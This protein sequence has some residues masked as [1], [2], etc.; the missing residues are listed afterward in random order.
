MIIFRLWSSRGIVKAL[1]CLAVVLTASLGTAVALAQETPPAPAKSD[2]GATAT[3]EGTLPPEAP[4]PAS[5]RVPAINPDEIVK[6]NLPDDM[7]LRVLVEYVGGLLRMKFIYDETFAPQGA[8]TSTINIKAFPQEVRMGEL[9]HLLETVLNMKNY[10]M[11]RAGEWVR[12]VPSSGP[13]NK[14][15]TNLPVPQLDV[16]SPIQPGDSIVRDIIKLK[17]ADPRDIVDVLSPFLSDSGSAIP[18]PDRGLL[19]L[20]DFSN[21]MEGLRRLVKLFDVPPKKMRQEVIELKY[22]RAPDLATRLANIFLARNQARVKVVPIIQQFPGGIQK[23]T[24][25]TVAAPPEPQ[26]F[27]DVNERNN[28]LV[29]MGSENDV[30]YLDD[31]IPIYDVPIKDSQEIKIY[32]LTYLAAADAMKSLQDLGLVGLE[33]TPG[34]TRRPTATRAPSMGGIVPTSPMAANN[35][36]GATGGTGAVARLSTLEAR[37]ALVIRATAE[38]HQRIK[39]FIDNADKQMK[40]MGNIR[41]YILER[42]DPDQITTVL[43]GV[44]KSTSFDARTKTPIPGE[45]GAPTF[46]SIPDIN[47]I[48]VNAS[49]SQ[50]EDIARIITEVDAQQPQVLLECTLVEVTD[51][52]TLDL[53]VELENVAPSATANVRNF[54]SSNFGFAPIDPKTG[55]SVFAN[56]TAT[57]VGTG[58]TYAFLDDGVVVALIRAL[59]TKSKGRVLSKPRILVNNNSKNAVIKSL[60]QEPVTQLNALTSNVTTQSFQQY[61]NAGTTLTITPHISDG[62]FLKLTIIMDVSSFVPTT[63]SAAA[64]TSV[65]P[66]STDRNMSTEITVPDQRTIVIGGLN[67]KHQ[68]VAIDQVPLLGDIPVIGELFKHRTVTDTNST[69]YLF[70]K[71]SILRDVTFSDLYRDTQHARDVMPADLQRLDPELTTQ[72]A[73][74]EAE[75]LN[76][77]IHRRTTEKAE[78]IRAQQ[79]LD[80]AKAAGSL[81]PVAQPSLPVPQGPGPNPAASTKSGQNG[82]EAH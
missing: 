12:I 10:T 31:L 48:I 11:I 29:L 23:T 68:T 45:E 1:L 41:V 57:A 72:A 6:M 52:D 26:P 58:G 59:E 9:Y 38:E 79:A 55:L 43:Q 3:P 77:V 7:N 16:L 73:E 39:E 27:I 76:E 33:L 21:R 61:V 5:P 74:K 62:N 82:A 20:M 18:L 30:A 63:A 19:V 56:G 40:V 60:N 53:G 22:A 34:A 15:P 47:A 35:P 50:H 70:V 78:K 67:D 24:Y 25:Q 42:R 69:I 64:G 28:A 4:P 66:P 80:K 17:A 32:E 81:E 75:R 46:V 51:S 8:P 49:P 36:A 2:Q 54:T 44:M 14:A 13:N 71:A 65:P 37:N